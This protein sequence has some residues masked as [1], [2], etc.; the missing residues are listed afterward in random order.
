MNVSQLGE[1]LLRGRDE[2]CPAPDGR[3]LTRAHAASGSLRRSIR[4]G[5]APEFLLRR[6]ELARRDGQQPIGRRA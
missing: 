1:L 4:A 5:D 2:L 3:S 6:G